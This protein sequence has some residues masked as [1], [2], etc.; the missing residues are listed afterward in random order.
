MVDNKVNDAM[1]VI[2]KLLQDV[3]KFIITRTW[4]R[5]CQVHQSSESA[6]RIG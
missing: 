4:L 1:W 5:G 3:M 2:R 6:T